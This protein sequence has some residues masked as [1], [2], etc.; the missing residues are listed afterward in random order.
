MLTSL[1]LAASWPAWAHAESQIIDQAKMFSPS[2]IQSAERAFKEFQTR[3]KVEIVVETIPN[4]QAID[5][6]ITGRLGPT[7]ADRALGKICEQRAADKGIRGLY[8]LI[9]RDPEKLKYKSSRNSINPQDT[10]MVVDA[11][12][13]SLK[14]REFDQALSSAAG[15]LERVQPVGGAAPRP[16]AAQQDSMSLS[17]LWTILLIGLGIWLVVGL[18]R[19][20]SGAGGGGGFFPSLL[21]GLFGGMAGMWMYDSFFRGGGSSGGD[22]Y[23]GG[24]S[25]GGDWGGGDSGGGDW[26]GGGDYGASGDF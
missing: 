16:R 15:V 4:L 17:P 7:E 8:I 22:G 24:A 1:M 9:C 10:R 6:K 3:T 19:A 14:N 20:M 26:G 23:D 18:M 21:G 11:V 13:S 5:P 25:G 12:M 2:A